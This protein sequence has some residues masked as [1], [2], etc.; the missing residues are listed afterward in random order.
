[1][2]IR[3]KERIT[4]DYG[5]G[6]KR[7]Y[8]LIRDTFLPRLSNPTLAQLADAARIGNFV[9]SCDS[10]T[11]NPIQFPSSDIGKLSIY[12]TVNDISVSAAYPLYLSLAIIIEE[13]FLKHDLERLVESVKEAKD[14]AKVE[15]VSGDFKVVER[16]KIDKIFIT[17]SG[18]GKRIP[19]TS[20]SI[21]KI[22]DRDK[23]IVTGSVGE[24]GI[25]VMLSRN[26][27]FDFD[28]KSDC[29]SLR[30]IL[31]PLWKNFPSIK[32]MRDPTRGGIAATLNEISLGSGL[33]IVLEEERI[34]LRE[35]TKAAC[36]ILGIDPYYLAC[37]GR[38]LIIAE[39]NEAREILKFLKKNN[40]RDAQIIGEV[41]SKL[42]KVVMQTLTGG[43]RILDFSYAFNLPRI[44]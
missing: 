25:A 36:E 41:S 21:K 17:T 27:I 32:F 42:E 14:K 24:H 2:K 5:D 16:G 9:F 10:F 34:P 1:M 8:E 23:V 28:I 40:C 3:M 26:K 13:G 29:Q 30:D 31:I 12:G 4:L 35:D 15:V 38:A 44:C 11:V 20:P 22:K 6:T 33:G 18:I 43:R 37:E 19:G 39:R 7:S